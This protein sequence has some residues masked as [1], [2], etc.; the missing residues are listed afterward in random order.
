MAARGGRGAEGR[1]LRGGRWGGR[2]APGGRC[3][4]ASGW[5][6]AVFQGANFNKEVKIEKSFNKE[7]KPKPPR[8]SESF[9]LDSGVL[10]DLCVAFGIETRSPSATSMPQAP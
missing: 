1:A 5:I 3:E 8:W 7:K 9:S 6:E 2:W 4:A 10:S